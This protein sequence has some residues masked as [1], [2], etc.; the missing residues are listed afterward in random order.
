M[1]SPQPT[2]VPS[3][4]AARVRRNTFILAMAAG[5]AGLMFG[6]DTGVIA[7][8]LTFIKEAFSADDRTLEWI[9]S[10]LMAAAAVGSVLAVF[11]ADK[12]GRKGTLVVAGILFLGGTALCSLAPSVPVMIAGRVCLGLGVGLA[13]FAAPLY[14][15]EI[16]SQDRRG[17]LIASYQ[18][19]ITVGILLAFTSDSLLTPG[20]HWR[21]MFGVLAVPTVLFLLATLV[22]PYSPRWLMTKG[23]REEARTVLLTL[24]ESAEIA[25]EELSRIDGQLAQQETPGMAL[26]L[27]SSSFRRTFTLGIA[28]QM[29]QQFS[30]INILMYYA[31]V[32]LGR[33]G[34]TATQ[35]VW[36]TT[37][38]GVVN[39]LATLVA[40]ALMDR[41]GRRSLLSISTF[42]SAVAMLGFGTLLWIGATSLSASIAAMGC[43]ILFIAAFAVGQGPLPWIICSEIQPIRGRTFA[44]S[45]STL[46][47]WIANWLVSNVFLS[48]MAV[49]NDY[50]VFWCLAAFNLTFFIVGLLFV[51][52]TK[53]CSLEDIEQKI[54]SGVR[55]RDA[56]Q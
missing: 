25:D 42:F 18:L 27:S 11:I 32:V 14:I 21:V 15:A 38:L 17:G 1:P 43:L 41:W 39:T 52:E 26:L 29:L 50:G 54:A 23:R 22:L 37:A 9:V 40:V 55:L 35:S 2:P 10:S 33:M 16:A 31:P 34:F 20:G 8:A 13:A 7:G 56:G 48:S 51:P 49:I 4:A 12:W 46:A 45:C 5:L 30:G 44:V 47:S 19:M 53:G 24:R 6:L 28:M 36:S 3:E